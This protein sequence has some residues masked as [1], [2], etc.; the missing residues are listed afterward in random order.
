MARRD[1]T[2]MSERVERD[3]SKG[4]EER[5]ASYIELDWTAVPGQGFSRR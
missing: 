2:V 1:M 5:A 4:E 3:L